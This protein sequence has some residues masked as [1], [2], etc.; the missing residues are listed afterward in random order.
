MGE[1]GGGGGVE[2]R[3]GGRAGKKGEKAVGEGG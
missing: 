1:D 2:R 3:W